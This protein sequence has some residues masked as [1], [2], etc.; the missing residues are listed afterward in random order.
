MTVTI[1]LT[2]GKT[3]TVDEADYYK[4]MFLSF[5]AQKTGNGSWY[6][7]DRNGKM[8]HRIILGLAN[9]DTCEVDHIDGNGLNNIRNNLRIATSAQNRQN[10]KARGQ[11]KGVTYDIN[12]H[13]YRVRIQ[14]NSRRLNLG[15]FETAE[16]AARVYDQK[17]KELHGVFAKL[18]FPEVQDGENDA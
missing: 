13:K 4:I 15:S 3:A 6:A 10:A 11:F 14:C 1:P 18:N 12:Q 16:E 2:K 7:S 9:D 17:A 5:K 8:L